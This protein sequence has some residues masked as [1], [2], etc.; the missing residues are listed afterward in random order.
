MLNRGVL[1]IDSGGVRVADVAVGGFTQQFN[2]GTP[3]QSNS[4]L[5][6][7]AD[8]PIN[9]IG[10]LGYAENN[11]CIADEGNIVQR[12]A[13]FGLTATGALSTSFIGPAV[14][15]NSGIPFNSSGRMLLSPAPG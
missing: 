12:V 6:I 7:T 2:G 15:W 5:V 3:T 13:G 10:G 1:N 8:P 4:S 9:F 14:N 11:L